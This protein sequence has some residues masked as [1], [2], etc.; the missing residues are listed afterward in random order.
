MDYGSLLHADENFVEQ[1]MIDFISFDGVAATD[2]ELDDNVHPASTMRVVNA[3]IK[4]DKDF[5]M[6]I[7]PNM[8]HTLREHDYYRRRVLEYFLENL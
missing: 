1:G 5:D 4:A 3:L 2:G 6:L 8:H 7:M